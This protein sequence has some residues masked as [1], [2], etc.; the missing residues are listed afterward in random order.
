MNW[1]GSSVWQDLDHLGLQ[2]VKD[3]EGHPAE[4]PE[5]VSESALDVC[6]KDKHLP[7]TPEEGTMQNKQLQPSERN[8]EYS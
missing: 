4:R 8:L 6:Q 1:E 5:M 7:L 2:G 3:R